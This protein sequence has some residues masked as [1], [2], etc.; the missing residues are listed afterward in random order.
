MPL[1]STSYVQ[2]KEEERERLRSRASPLTRSLEALY[3]LWLD[4]PSRRMTLHDQLAVAETARPAEFFARCDAL[5]LRVDDQGFTR[6]D[7]AQGRETTVCFE[8]KREAFM[9]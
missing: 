5:R 7:N 1:D 8:P 2:L 9:K 6:I 4:N 3:R